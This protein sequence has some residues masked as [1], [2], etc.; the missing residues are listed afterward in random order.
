MP[1]VHGKN[2]AVLF[3]ASDLTAFFNDSSTSRAIETAETTVYGVASGAKTYIT[4]LQDATVS[5]GGLYDG[6]ANAVDPVLAGALAVQQVNPLLVSPAG[7]AFGNRAGIFDVIATSYEVTSPVA[8]VC[9]ISAE[10]QTTGTTD[11]AVILATG[12]LSATANGTSVDN[13][14]ASTTGGTAQV[15]VTANTRSTTTVLKVQHSSDN[16]TFVDL[17]TFATVAISGTTSER[18]AVA[19]GTSILR[20]VRAQS[21]LTAGTGSITPHIAFARS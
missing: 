12:A 1:F 4:G 17:A 15:H 18:V 21:T 11:T 14:A 13:G 3:R 7:L 5:T 16:T 6:A 2:T 8:D 20:Y 10:F 19:P 9:A